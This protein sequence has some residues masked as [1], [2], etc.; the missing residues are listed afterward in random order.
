MMVASVEIRYMDALEMDDDVVMNTHPK[1]QMIP[2]DENKV[3]SILGE[4]SPLFTSKAMHQLLKER[5]E[6]SQMS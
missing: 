4:V 6:I 2:H 5:W 3:V 1:Y